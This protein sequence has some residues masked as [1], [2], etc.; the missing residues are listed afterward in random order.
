MRNTVYLIGPTI[1]IVLGLYAF[2][3]VPVTFILFYGFLG[4]VCLLH[5]KEEVLKITPISLFIG[6]GSGALF[7]ITIFGGVWLFQDQLINVEAVRSLLKEWGFSGLGLIFVLIVINPFLEELYW[8]GV[9]L[10]RLG[11]SGAAIVVTAIFYSLYHILS[12][13]LLFTWPLNILL[14]LPVFLAGLFWAIVRK[15]TGSLV[16]VMISHLLADAGIMSIYWFLIR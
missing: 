1:M 14:V 2:S 5:R 9:M 15:K 7:Y 13:V 3:S 6:M 4:V 11:R 8:R 12:V 16:S 10:N